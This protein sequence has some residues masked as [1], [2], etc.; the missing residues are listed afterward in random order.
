VA[1]LAGRFARPTC[2][3]A[4]PRSRGVDRAAMITSID[5]PPRA[6]A[7]RDKPDGVQSWALAR[8]R[9]VG[10]RAMLSFNVKEQSRPVNMMGLPLL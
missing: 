8:S 7:R 4:S 5:A 10:S 6:E 1:R 9:R 2:R 3:G